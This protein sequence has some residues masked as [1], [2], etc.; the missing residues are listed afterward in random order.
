MFPKIARSFFDALHAIE[1]GTA[2][3]IFPNG[4]LHQFTGR[5]PGSH[6]QLTLHNWNGVK[7][8]LQKG[9][10][11]FAEA[12]RDGDWDSEDICELLLCALQNEAAMHRYIHGSAIMRV[13]SNL[14]YFFTRNTLTGSRK[15]IQAHYDIGNDFYALWLDP[16]MTYSSALFD[17]AHVALEAA[18]DAKY[19]RI[20]SRLQPGGSLLEIG[21]GWGGFAERAVQKSGFHIRGITLSDQQQ[22][23]AAARLQGKAEIV[24][25]DYRNQQGTYDS[26]VSIE[27]FEAVGEKYWPVYFAKIKQLL[28]EKGRAVIQ[29]ITI[30]EAEFER[31]R[32]SGDM[33]RTYIFPGGMLPTASRFK[34]EAEAAGLK[35]TD[36][37]CFGQD[38]GTTLRLW[39]HRFETALPDVR[40]LGYDEKFIRLWR[41]YLASCFASFR[42]GRTNVMQVELQHA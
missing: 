29:T 24:L 2:S 39:L 37:H 5:Q 10:I 4:K 42:V 41:F 15:N 7:Q 40:A 33:I 26:I 17:E 31:Y 18:Q 3:I 22:A 38:Y 20:I 1:Y 36:Q 14:A 12:Y 9:D 25:E 8:L 19:D 11:G 16:G 21:C 35:V 6:A 27:M 13:L 30:D 28:A 23:Y 32:S 34:Q